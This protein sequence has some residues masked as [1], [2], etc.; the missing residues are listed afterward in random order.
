MNPLG[1][2]TASAADP[3][4]E[5]PVAPEAPEVME[6]TPASFV[7]EPEIET[8][9][10][11]HPAPDGF[12]EGPAEYYDE[13]ETAPVTGPLDADD[14]VIDEV[15]EETPAPAYAA[16]GSIYETPAMHADEPNASYIR[17]YSASNRDDGF[18][19]TVIQEKNGKQR[20]ALL[21]GSTIF[22]LTAVMVAWGVSLF[23]KELGVGSIGD[24]RSLAML[25]D[26]VPMPVDEVEPENKNDDEGGGGGGGGKEEPEPVSQGD[27]APQMRN[28]PRP[29]D[30][31]VH[32]MDNPELQLPQA[33]TEG[34]QQFEQRYGR[35]GDPNALPG[36]LSNGPG[37]GGGMG[38]GTGTG[39]GSG[40]GTGA[41]SG[42]GSGYGSG[43]GTGTGSGTGAG[44]GGPPPP[45]APAVTVNYRIIA[46]PKATYT[47]AARTN[48][49]QGNVRL[50][51]T[52]LASGQVGPIT[53]VTRLPHGLTEQA[54]AAARQIRFEPK[55]VN[56]RATSV[57]VTVDYGFNIY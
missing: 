21:L 52:L 18:Y 46:K 13:L 1:N 39:Q 3:V 9:P 32:R 20:N 51:V 48:G 17:D 56:G 36:A 49:V 15:A 31:K 10:I 44:S 55:K 5:E 28:P 22:M 2:D 47:D 54:I 45:A 43:V 26:E 23:Q 30:A 57:V 53:P 16:A 6:A 35:W 40:R 27:L 50:K 41:G 12:S 19:V 11:A 4:I 14:G 37:T 33:A 8:A 34:T 24:E 7:D 25:I 38:S 42:T 29:P